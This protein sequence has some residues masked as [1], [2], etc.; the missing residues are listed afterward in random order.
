MNDTNSAMRRMKRSKI[1]Q[2][3]SLMATAGFTLAACG[4]PPQQTATAPEGEWDAP[5]PAYSSVQ[6]CV[7]SGE[8][9]QECEAAFKAASAEAAETAPRFASQQDCEQEWGQG[10]CQQTEHKGSSFFMPMLAGFMMARMMNGGQQLGARPM[11]TERAQ[12][13][14][15]NRSRAVSRGGFGNSRGSYGG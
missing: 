7:S 2:V 10:Q 1:L 5:S 11:G 14:D 4:S 6:A 13:V 3:S 8:P 15:N 9:A 12:Q